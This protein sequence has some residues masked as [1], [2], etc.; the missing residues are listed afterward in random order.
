MPTPDRDPAT[1]RLSN[2]DS[3]SAERSG[4]RPAPAPIAVPPRASVAAGADETPSRRDRRTRRLRRLTSQVRFRP[5][6][7]LLEQRAL[8]SA[9]PTV[10]ALRASTTSAA[11]GQSVAF[12]ATV[13]DFSAGGTTPNGGTVTFNENGG[14]IG[15]ATL[16]DGVA[17]FTT[18]SLAAGA[19]TIAAFYGGTAEFASS[20]TGL[21]VNAAGN[22][23]S[24]YEGDNG[25]APLV[26]LP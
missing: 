20:S 16:V 26:F 8:L 5:Q 21:I 13:S 17:T 2:P 3:R 14:T 1:D 19:N 7:V 11:L 24:G 10:T 22:H 9:L 15:S 4:A 12:T 25:P 6:I 23:T 18:S